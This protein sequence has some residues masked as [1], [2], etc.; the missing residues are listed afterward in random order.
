MRALLDAEFWGW[1]TI[2]AVAIGLI[3]ALVFVIRFQIEAG[4]SWWHSPFGRFLM[5]RKVLLA[6]LF[7]I[8]LLNRV[9]PDWPLREMVT[10]LLMLAFALQ[11]FVPYRLLVK[12]QRQHDT[13]HTFDDMDDAR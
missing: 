9:V 13:S 1:L 3:A 6:C 5:V 10:A 7:T 8:V 12:V 4:W 11:T 2:G